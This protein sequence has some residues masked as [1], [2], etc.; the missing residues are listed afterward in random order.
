MLSFDLLSPSCVAPIWCQTS[1][2]ATMNM[3]ICNCATHPRINLCAQ[4]MVSS[5]LKLPAAHLVLLSLKAVVASVSVRHHVGYLTPTTP[6]GNAGNQ[7]CYAHQ[8]SQEL[9]VLNKPIVA[10]C[11]LTIPDM[12]CGP[13]T[14]R[15][16]EP[17]VHVVPQ[18]SMLY[19]GYN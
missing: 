10:A 14:V 8:V 16:Y 15:P 2:P 6:P 3:I 11:S 13:F 17:A 12:L 5:R 4:V 7:G 19:H 9:G 18:C 1:C